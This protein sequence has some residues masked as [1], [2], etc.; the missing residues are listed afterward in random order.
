M[1]LRIHQHSIGY[2]ATAFTG[3]KTQPTESKY[4]RNNRVQR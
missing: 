4:W 2:T 3:R 1:V